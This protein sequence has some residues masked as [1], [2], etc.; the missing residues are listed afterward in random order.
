MISFWCW[1][2]RIIYGLKQFWPKY[3]PSLWENRD[4]VGERWNYCLPGNISSCLSSNLPKWDILSLVHPTVHFHRGQIMHILLNNLAGYKHPTVDH[5]ELC[6]AGHNFTQKADRTHPS[7]QIILA[8]CVRLLNSGSHE[9]VL[10]GPKFF[11][12]GRSST[13]FFLKIHCPS[14]DH[15]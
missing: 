4:F 2:F 3:S 1:V 12:K 11:I 10:C 14:V 9:F 7:L 15:R 13:F 5:R 6:F 8:V